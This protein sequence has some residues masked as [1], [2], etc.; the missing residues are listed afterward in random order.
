MFWN[1]PHP[2]ADL[3]ADRDLAEEI[4]HGGEPSADREIRDYRNGLTKREFETW[5]RN[6]PF[7]DGLI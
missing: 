7:S 1:E 3:M 2:L 4:R 6:D 5:I